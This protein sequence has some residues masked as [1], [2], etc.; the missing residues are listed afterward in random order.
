MNRISRLAAAV[1][2]SGGLGL[3]GVAGLTP[4]TG[5]AHADTW[6]PGDYLFTGMPNWDMGICHEYYW[7]HKYDLNAPTTLFIEG[8][9]PGPPAPG[10]CGRDMFTGIPLPC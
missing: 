7:A 8:L 10:F 4:G 9:P 1:V 6:C 3:A 5:T 2:V